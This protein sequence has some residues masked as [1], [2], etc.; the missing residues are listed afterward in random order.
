LILLLGTVNVG[1]WPKTARLE[2]DGKLP[3]LDWLRLSFIGLQGCLGALKPVGSW[4]WAGGLRSGSPGRA[5]LKQSGIWILSWLPG[6]GLKTGP[7]IWGPKDRLRWKSRWES[8][9]LCLWPYAGFQW[10]ARVSWGQNRRG[11][12]VNRGQRWKSRRTI[13]K[14]GYYSFHFG[15]G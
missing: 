2:S 5:Q 7:G 15:T 10:V 3:E 12:G 4:L 14:S 6:N 1:I 13:N 8:F 9:T 11:S